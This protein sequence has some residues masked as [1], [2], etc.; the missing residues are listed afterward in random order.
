MMEI[1]KKDKTIAQDNELSGFESML[2]QIPFETGSSLP[3]W[4]TSA[5]VFIEKKRKSI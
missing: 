2:A 1:P 4:R 5:N 3:V